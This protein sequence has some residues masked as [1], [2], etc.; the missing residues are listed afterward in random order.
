M[1]SFG[2]G[3]SCRLNL[4]RQVQEILK[5]GRRTA[6]GSLVLYWDAKAALP[7]QQQLAI[8]ISS[9]IAP[10]FARNRV[11]R[12]LREIFRLHR[13]EWVAGLRLLILVKKYDPAEWKKMAIMEAALQQSFSQNG[14]LK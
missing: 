12:V 1:K 6:A 4:D 7:G 9:K 14:I 5:S 2:L 10:A 3:K 8:R 13:R 11:K